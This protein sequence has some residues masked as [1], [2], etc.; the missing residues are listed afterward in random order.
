MRLKKTLAALI[1][2]LLML[3][4]A[5]TGLAEETE[6]A[7]EAEGAVIPENLQES[8][9]IGSWRLTTI[10]M[11]G[12]TFGAD[13]LGINMRYVFGEDHTARGVYVGN[14]GDSGQAEEPWSLDAKQGLIYVSDKPFLKVR[15]E[16]GVLFLLMDEEISVEATGDLVFTRSEEDE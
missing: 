11:E 1:S 8:D 15:S 7:A 9:I 12:S 14:M 6:Q 13:M 3:C 16:D 10:T 5:A 4:F 2:C